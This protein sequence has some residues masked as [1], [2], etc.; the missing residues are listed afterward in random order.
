MSKMA[1]YPFELWHLIFDHLQ[2]TNIASCARVSKALYFAVKAYR[3]WSIAFT[4][5]VDE[6]FHY[7]KL[8]SNHK[9][10]LDFRKA[11]LLKRSSFNFGCLKRLKIGESSLIDLDVINKFT[12]LEEL[13]IELKSY[14]KKNSRTLSLA[15]LKVLCLFVPGVTRSVKLDTP[16][17]AKV[18]TFS[19]KNLQFVYP[20]SV[21]CIHAFRVAKLWRFENLEYLTLTDCYNGPESPINPLFNFGAKWS[22][23]QLKE[24]NFF[25]SGGADS[26]SF[27]SMTADL[28]VR[29]RPNLKIFWQNV[30]ITDPNLLKEY[31]RWMKS[32]EGRMAF[33]LQHYEQLENKIELFWF[34]DFNKSM[35]T[36]KEA[37]LNPRSDEFTSKFLATCSLRKI[38]VIGRVNE[39]EVLMKLIAGS[40]NLL[41]LEFEKTG[42]RQSFF[43]RM[44]DV[45]IRNGIPLRY[46]HLR[47]KMSLRNLWFANKIPDL[48][49]FR[50]EEIKM[51]IALRRLR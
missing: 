27:R 3:I 18:F 2:L 44:A 48:K 36:F 5:G 10:R 8:S 25:Y 1:N 9:Y 7:T 24:I 42:L 32:V 38:E 22:L 17:L 47:G 39:Q 30:P 16:R 40:P 12:P 26:S 41:S 15:N 43:D 19:L 14:E 46:L 45:V 49:Q 33:Q 29:Q 23:V 34:C 31:G 11:G 37:G 35:R 4:G 28:L 6:W 50:A 13:D 21:R 20:K 51:Q